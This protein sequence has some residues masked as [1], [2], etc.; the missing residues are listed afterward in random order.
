MAAKFTEE[1]LNS[2]DRSLL[3]QM[4]LNLQDQ[5]EELTR[6]IHELN[7]KMQLMMEQLI[8]AKK[9]RFGRSSEKMEDPDQICFKEVDG[10]KVRVFKSNGA[11]VGA[12]A[13]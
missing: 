13:K 4:I 6:E 9:N 1:Q 5:S 3:I 12:K 10:K 8:L 7:E 11:V 2:A